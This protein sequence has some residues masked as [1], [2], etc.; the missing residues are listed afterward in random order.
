MPYSQIKGMIGSFNLCNSIWH[1]EHIRIPLFKL[2]LRPLYL[3]LGNMW[4]AD[5]CLEVLQYTQ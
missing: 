5:K 3:D 4:C 1:F 2:Y